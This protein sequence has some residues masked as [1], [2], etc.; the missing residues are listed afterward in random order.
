MDSVSD[1]SISCDPSGSHE[2]CGSS[3]S[4]SDSPAGEG[5]SSV[6][7]RESV[8]ILLDVASSL[9]LVVVSSVA[10]RLEAESTE[11]S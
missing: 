6:V 11:L 10:G 9:G 3:E 7:A 4:S 1:I 8:S 5:S 2:S